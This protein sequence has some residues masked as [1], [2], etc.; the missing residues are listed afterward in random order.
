MED[1]MRGRKSKPKEEKDLAG[2][3]DKKETAKTVRPVKRMLC[4]RWMPDTG[5][6]LWRKL[7]PILTDLEI[8]TELDR[9]TFEA[10][11]LSYSLMR[12][13][14]EELAK[15][16]T[17]KAER[18]STIKKAP[19]FT[20]YKTNADLYRKFAEMFALSPMVRKRLGIKTKMPTEKERSGI[21]TMVKK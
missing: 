8:L 3:P 9:P 19:Q 12:A 10:L 20:I 5:K 11:C 14:G 4:P 13:S 7:S 16:L 6:K 17:V 1:K 2:S 15:G 21:L 18:G